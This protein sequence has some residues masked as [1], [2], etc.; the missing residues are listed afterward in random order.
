MLN[1]CFGDS[2]CGALRQALPW[3]QVTFSYRG[4]ELGRIS[5][6]YFDE[7]RKEWI[8]EFFNIC[9]KRE[10]AKIWKDEQSRVAQIIET[11]KREKELRIWYASSPC[12]TCGYYKLVHMLHDTECTIYVVEM[13]KQLGYR[14]ESCDK[15]W[16]EVHPED[17]KKCL[18][19]QRELTTK[20]RTEIAQKWEQLA[21]E[22]EELRLNVNGVLSSVPVDYL[23][24]EIL[25]YAPQDKEF[26]LGNL[27]G[28]VIG[29]CVHAIS[30]SFI[31]AR[32]E[33]MVDGGIFTVI[34]RPKKHQDYYSKTIMRVSTEEDKNELRRRA[35]YVVEFLENLGIDEYAIGDAISDENREK[36]YEIIIKHPKM[37]KKQALKRLQLEEYEPNPLPPGERTYTD[38]DFKKK[39]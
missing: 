37:S 29:K 39:P 32:I 20:E 8:D 14:D 27:V 4:L 18:V 3:E 31:S 13:P 28:S 12:S 11:A 30:D 25:S 23:D 15:S 16:G 19:L 26:K 2:E 10:R 17:M 36:S 22:N 7:S 38:A 35:Q 34:E 9:S 24:E 6:D 33:S 1:V 5:N 21:E